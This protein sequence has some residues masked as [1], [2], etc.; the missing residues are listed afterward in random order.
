M[1]SLIKWR[2]CYDSTD[3]IMFAGYPTFKGQVLNGEQLWELIQGLESNDLLY[4]THL[5]TGIIHSSIDL[6]TCGRKYS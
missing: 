3:L 5:L 1:F 2:G 4:Y 6:L